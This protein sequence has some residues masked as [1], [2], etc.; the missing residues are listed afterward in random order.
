MADKVRF[1]GEFWVGITN[2]S[3]FSFKSAMKT[4]V[5]DIFKENFDLIFEHLANN[6]QGG[7]RVT[8]EDL[9]SLLFGDFMH[10]DLSQDERYYEEIKFI[11]TMYNVVELYLDDYNTNHKNKMDLVVFRFVF[12]L[13]T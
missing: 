2:T 3:K 5:N 8:E 6:G 9:R 7:G 12:V 10:V 13:V 11:E 1:D 4:C